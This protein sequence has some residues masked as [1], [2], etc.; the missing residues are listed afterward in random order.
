MR[1]MTIRNRVR[2]QRRRDYRTRRHARPN[3]HHGKRNLYHV[4]ANHCQ[5]GNTNTIGVLRQIIILVL[6][7]RVGLVRQ[8]VL[9]VVPTTVITNVVV[10]KSLLSRV[11]L[12]IVGRARANRRRRRGNSCGRNTPFILR[13]CTH[14]KFGLLT[15]WFRGGYLSL[16][17]EVPTY[18][19]W[20]QSTH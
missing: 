9:A 12:K 8:I 2:K 18:S 19:R 7:I 20:E 6:V 1:V 4:I 5:N 11:G 15:I 14:L 13:R 10:V 16:L 3:R 17:L